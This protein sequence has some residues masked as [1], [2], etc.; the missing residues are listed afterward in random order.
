MRATDGA[1]NQGIATRSFTVET[2]AAPP[3]PTLTST[4]PASPANQNSP[5][6]TGSATAGS[7]V[8]LYSSADCT[9]APLGGGSA[10]ELEAGITI[11]VPDNSSTAI[12]ATATAAGATSACSGPITYV[13]DSAAP[14]TLLGAHPAALSAS[15][16]GTFEFTGE[17]PGGSG[18]ASFQ[19][20]LDSTE[21]A[22]WASCSS[23]KAYTGLAEGAHRFEARAIDRA[24]NTDA[25]PATF[26]W[27]VD[28]TAPTAV[29]DSGPSGTTTSQ[30]PTFTFHSTEGGSTFAC[31]IDTGTASFGAC[32]GP[33]ASHTPPSPTAQRDLH[34]PGAGH[35]RRRQPGDR[36]PQLHG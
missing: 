32:S 19:C 23:P 36:D 20:R 5:K 34:L 27:Q 1:G 6:V 3:A 31:S 18:V 4:L 17:D 35:R 26:E 33:G 30:T 13:E 8:A 24:A 11:S 14:Q 21:A 7:Q 10:S 16:S 2:V 9:G 22:A 15:A 25:S 28:T 29:I 12:R